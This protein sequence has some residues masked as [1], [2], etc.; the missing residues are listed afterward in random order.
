MLGFTDDIVVRIAGDDKSARIDIRSSSRFGQHDFGA[1][2]ARVRRFTR[3]LQSRL[4]TFVPYGVAGR[5]GVR[6][7][8]AMQSEAAA[9]GP[10]RPLERLREKAGGRGERDPAPTDARRAPQPKEKP[11]G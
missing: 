10:K 8:R 1:N 7:T 11:R 9:A 6:A 5:G 2:A 4:E 3:E